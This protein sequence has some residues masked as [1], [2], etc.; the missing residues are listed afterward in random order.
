MNRTKRITI[1]FSDK[2]I[3]LINF[4]NRQQNTSLSIRLICKKWIA[5]HGTGD[6][7]DIL[8]TQ[9]DTDK[10]EPPSSFDL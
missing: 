7:V 8:T 2:D 3:D 4:I 6:V 10:S 1:S 5:E 9:S